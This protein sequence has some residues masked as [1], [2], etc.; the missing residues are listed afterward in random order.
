MDHP[1]EKYLY[2]PLNMATILRYPNTMAKES[3]K[4]LQK[5]LGNNVVIV[6]DHLYAIDRDM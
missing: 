3:H 5:F 2:K 1:W 4:R 6:D